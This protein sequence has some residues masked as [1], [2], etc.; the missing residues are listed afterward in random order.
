MAFFIGGSSQRK[1]S[2]KE[3]GMC[4]LPPP[5]RPSEYPPQTPACPTPSEAR[6]APSL[7]TA[8]HRSQRSKHAQLTRPPIVFSHLGIPN[9]FLETVLSS[10]PATVVSCTEYS[11]GGRVRMRQHA[12]VWLCA[13]ACAWLCA[14]CVY[15]SCHV[16]P[17][18]RPF[19]LFIRRRLLM[20]EEQSQ[21]ARLLHGVPAKGAPK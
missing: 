2:T 13:A 7:H 19:I 8:P 5:T 14:A 10:S 1:D 9:P 4:P 6:D 20:S 16:L 17:A 18:R 15:D 21:H 11:R 12:T 3:I